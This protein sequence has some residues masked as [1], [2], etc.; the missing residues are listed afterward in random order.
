MAIKVID[1]G[2]GNDTVWIEIQPNYPVQQDYPNLTVSLGVSGKPQTVAPGATLTLTS[3]ENVTG[4][5]GDDR[6]TGN[7]H[8]NVIDGAGGNDTLWGLG[9]DDTLIG[10]DGM[11]AARFSNASSAET[12]DLLAGTASGGDGND[13]LSGIENVMGSAFG[14]TISG[15]NGVNQL[16]GG[17]GADIMSGR[18]GNDT[19]L[20][21]DSG[22]QAIEAVNGGTDTVNASVSFVLG[23]N[24]KI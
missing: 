24:L 5:Y 16:D 3:I 8:D 13:T 22:D 19:Y 20:V 7:S 14:D 1:G 18:G 2:A 11:D 4:Y 9:G 12:I 6:L 15:D 10:G 21:D 23:D 17:A